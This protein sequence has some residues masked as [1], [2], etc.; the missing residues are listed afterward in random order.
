MAEPARLPWRVFQTGPTATTVRYDFLQ[1]L[2]DELNAAGRATGSPSS[3]NEFDLEAP[4]DENG[5]QATALPP[6]D[7]RRGDQRPA[8]DARRHPR[9]GST[10]ACKP[11]DADAGHFTTL[12]PVP[13]LGTPP[14]R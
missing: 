9:R 5:I 14:F 1:D 3:Q 6:R 2:L 11:S 12:L 13:I 10:P 8:D 7:P 4:A